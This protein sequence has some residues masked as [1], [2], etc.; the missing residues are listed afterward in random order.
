MPPKAEEKA[1]AEHDGRTDKQE[2]ADIGLTEEEK[3]A[4]EGSDSAA[5]D[6]DKSAQEGDKPTDDKEAKADA[7]AEGDDKAKAAAGEKEETGE[8]EAAK[9]A[10]AVPDHFVPMAE[11]LSED[12]LKEIDDALGKLKSDFDDGEIDYEE[13][14]DQRL[15]LEKQIWHHE[16]AVINNEGA[17][18][19]RWK[20]E[21]EWYLQSNDEL[22][23]NQVIYGAFASQ[24]N[25]LMADDDWGVRPGFDILQEAHRL[26]ASEIN[27]LS[28]PGGAIPPAG[29]GGK[30]KAAADQ[31][32][33]DAIKAAK[34]AESG[35]KPP[36]TLAKVPAAE[37]NAD[38]SKWAAIDR[39]DG[40]EY[41]NAI[42][43]LSPAQLAEYEAYSG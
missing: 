28:G 9:K 11:T 7:T 36:E 40:E 15:A 12:D 16:Q 3:A 33:A 37:D 6:E 8:G 14:N 42:A 32:A 10:A 30:T 25:A 31:K 13:Y 39:L 17:I 23:G 26:V 41:E 24:V 34:A 4:L 27:T 22:T 20:W 29:P 35:K 1:A 19:Q 38:T 43:S 2:R 18:E 21:Q 5:A